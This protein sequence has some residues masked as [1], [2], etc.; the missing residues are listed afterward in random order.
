VNSS[1]VKKIEKRKTLN[2]KIAKGTTMT[3]T[4]AVKIDGMVLEPDNS[5]VD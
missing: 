2:D 4:K 1:V 3:E 5:P